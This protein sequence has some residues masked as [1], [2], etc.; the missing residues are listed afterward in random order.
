MTYYYD[1]LVFTSWGFGSIM[2]LDALSGELVDKLRAPNESVFYSDPVYSE[3]YDMFCTV[4]YKDVVGF[5]VKN[6]KK[7]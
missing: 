5:T 6:P 2:V 4:S 3:K 7:E 1:L